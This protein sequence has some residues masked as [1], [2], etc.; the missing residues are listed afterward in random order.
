MPCLTSLPAAPYQRTKQALPIVAF[1]RYFVTART[2]ETKANQMHQIIIFIPSF[3]GRGGE[4]VGCL[5]VTFSDFV[6]SHTWVRHH[7]AETSW[8]NLR[9]QHYLCVPMP[10]VWLLLGGLTRLVPK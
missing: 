3:V 9:A 5:A 6:P 2:K 1:C 7:L 4:V 8:L 10:S